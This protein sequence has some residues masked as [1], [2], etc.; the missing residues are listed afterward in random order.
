MPF[1][2]DLAPSSGGLSPV[3][4]KATRPLSCERLTGGLSLKQYSAVLAHVFV[5]PRGVIR[6]LTVGT[7]AERSHYEPVIYVFHGPG[8][9]SAKHLHF[10]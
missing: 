1:V 8:S 6:G 3:I 10:W 9:A 5:R 7:S 4:S 2:R